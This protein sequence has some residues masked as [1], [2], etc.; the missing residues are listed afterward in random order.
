M[1]WG[2]LPCHSYNSFITIAKSFLFNVLLCSTLSI[3]YFSFCCAVCMCLHGLLSFVV[4]YPVV[5]RLNE[6]VTLR[7]S[8]FIRYRIQCNELRLAEGSRSAP[9]CIVFLNYPQQY[10][11]LAC[12]CASAWS[13]A[14]C[15]GVL[16]LVP[17]HLHPRLLHTM[18]KCVLISSSHICHE[19]YIFKI[20]T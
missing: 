15:A 12:A 11:V 6:T 2:S 14:W 13:S 19:I 18:H 3:Y 17:C 8:T 5:H 4:R 7:T 10:C 1:H 9:V 16:M 20:Q